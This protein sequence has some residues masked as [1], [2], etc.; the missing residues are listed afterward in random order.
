MQISWS[1]FGKIQLFLQD[2]WFDSRKELLSRT[3][4]CEKIRQQRVFLYK[5]S[6][7]SIQLDNLE[8]QDFITYFCCFINP[9]F[10][11]YSFLKRKKKAIDCSDVPWHIWF[12]P[13]MTSIHSDW[14]IRDKDQLIITVADRC[15]LYDRWP[16]QPTKHPLTLIIN[17]WNSWIFSRT[18]RQIF[19]TKKL[20]AMRCFELYGLWASPR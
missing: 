7:K 3:A 9:E 19:S 11:L 13:R 4:Y 12:F 17:S 16:S 18:L 8:F 6:K 10:T 5:Y 14:L 15:Q 2:V 20:G 1:K